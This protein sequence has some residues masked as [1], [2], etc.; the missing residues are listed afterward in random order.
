MKGRRGHQQQQQCVN[1]IL[2]LPF[3]IK[4]RR[5][6]EEEQGKEGEEEEDKMFRR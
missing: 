4:N 2:Q 3:T 1:S 5:V 6:K